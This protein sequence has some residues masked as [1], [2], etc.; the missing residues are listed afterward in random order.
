MK[1][2]IQHYD[3]LIV[4]AGLAGLTVALSLPEQFK[5]ALLAKQ[6]LNTC[7]SNMAQGGIAAVLDPQDTVDEHVQD[8]LV[9]GAGLCHVE[10][11]THILSHAAQAIDWLCQ[12]GVPFTYHDQNLHLTREGGHGQRRIVHAADH[13]GWSVTQTLQQQL[14]QKHNVTCLTEHRL[15]QLY[16]EDQRC[17]GAELKDAAQQSVQVFAKYVILATGGTGQLFEL[18]TNPETSTGDGVALAWQAGCRV[19]NLEF[20]QFHPTALALKGSKTFLISEALR[21]EGGILRNQQG[22]RFMPDYDERLEL[23]PRDIVARAIADQIQKQQQQPV[24]LDMTHLEK[25]FITEHFP[26]IYQHCLE[27]GLDISQQP[28]PVAPAAHYACGGVLTDAIGHTDIENLFAIGEVACTGLH[29]ANRLASNSLLECMVMGRDVAQA[30]VQQDEWQ[31]PK[32]EAELVRPN[33]TA[34]ATQFEL[35]D[36][37][38][39]ARLQQK[40]TQYFGIQRDF[41]GMQYLYAQLNHWWLMTEQQY[42]MLL[43]AMLM[44]HS[45]LQRQESRGTHFNRDCPRTLPEAEMS[46]I[47][48]PVQ[49]AVPQPEATSLVC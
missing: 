35:E 1:Q 49:Q 4:G 5:I 21:G 44:V 10:N 12:F 32:S 33:F 24:L 43:T 9:A 18:T 15:Q 39:V 38:D 28:I 27:Q 8:T 23:A 22:E 42:P 36:D 19:A 26:S 20:I 25:A 45:A 11:T 2:N 14:A 31:V 34:V 40:M 41:A 16:V 30:I 29:G 13:T 6:D 46:V 7:S 47:A 37:F 48:A 17:Y 3:V